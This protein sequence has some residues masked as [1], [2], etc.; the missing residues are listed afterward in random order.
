MN[1]ENFAGGGCR[2]ARALIERPS[3]YPHAPYAKHR[4]LGR[5]G[6]S[7]PLPLN[8]PLAPAPALD[9]HSTRRSQGQ[10]HAA[11]YSRLSSVYRGLL[12]N[13]RTLCPRSNSQARRG[14]PRYFSGFGVQGLPRRNL[15]IPG[16]PVG[17]PC[18]TESRSAPVVRGTTVRA[19][20]LRDGV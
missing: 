16:T 10:G 19:L 1:A 7:S 11:G 17:K 18:V 4:W 20:F 13:T 6:R 14:L 5:D 15:H 12:L 9:K 3:S 2:A 8:C